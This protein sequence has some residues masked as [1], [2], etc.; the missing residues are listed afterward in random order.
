MGH[1]HNRWK[2]SRTFNQNQDESAVEY[3]P[4]A[5]CQAYPMLCQHAVSAAGPD[6]K[7][8]AALALRRLSLYTGPA[9]Y[10]PMRG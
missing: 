5:N 3:H 2:N 4:T 6:G 1:H 9:F 7:S 10:W 8:F